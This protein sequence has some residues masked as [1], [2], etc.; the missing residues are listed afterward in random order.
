LGGAYGRQPG[1]STANG[2]SPATPVASTSDDKN[3]DKD[4]AA[5]NAGTDTKDK[6]GKDEEG[7]GNEEDEED[8]GASAV[9]RPAEKRKRTPS[10]SGAD[11]IAG[12]MH[13][14]E[15]ADEPLLLD[16]T[17]ASALVQRV[18]SQ[19]QT[20]LDLLFQAQG[21]GRLAPRRR[22]HAS[23]DPGLFFIHSVLVPPNKFRPVSVMNDT[24]YEHA[25]NVILVKVLKACLDIYDLRSSVHAMRAAGAAAPD[26]VAKYLQH[27][28]ALQ[29]HVS[30]CLLPVCHA[31]L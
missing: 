21:G 14:V 27:C 8:L 2:S 20:L 13:A 11:G 10:S 5:S 30:C 26:I 4:G 22:G 6:A 17:E 19:D 16:A 25:H 1:R 9:A 31:A 24:K 23:S 3:N 18:W 7:D 28:K 15:R 12:I 29:N